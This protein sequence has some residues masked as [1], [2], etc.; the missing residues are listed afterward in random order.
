[1]AKASKNDIAGV[2]SIGVYIGKEVFHLVGFDGDGKL[3]LRRKIKRLALVSTFEK[4]PR[5]I[6]GMEA[7]LSAHFV[8]RTLRRLG[9]KPR[10]IP[11]KYTRPFVKG[12]KND[13][14]DAEA[15]AEAALRPNLKCASEKTQDQ[16]DLQAL[17]RV[18]SRLVSRRTATINQIRAFLIEQGI[19][20]RTGSSALRNSLFAILKNRDDEISQRMHDIIIGLYEDWLWLDERIE[21]TSTECLGPLKLCHYLSVT[22]G[23]R[24]GPETVF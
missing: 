17:H 21:S 24:D 8:S 19:T 22:G 23:T 9:F 4:F 5:C 18:R 1:M 16:L 15:I 11:A 13:Y 2:T 12:Q 7:C 3:V 14:N 6:V 20:V 10:V